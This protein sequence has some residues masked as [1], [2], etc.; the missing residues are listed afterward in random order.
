MPSYLISW[1]STSLALHSPRLKPIVF[2]HI[3]SFTH[4]KMWLLRHPFWGTYPT[5]GALLSHFTLF[6]LNKL[7]HFKKIKLGY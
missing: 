1:F 7:S 3:S 4:F 2:G 6:Y 5:L